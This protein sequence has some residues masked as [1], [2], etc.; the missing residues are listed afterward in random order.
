MNSFEFVFK[1]NISEYV[2]DFFMFLILLIPYKS[3]EII[4][5]NHKKVLFL[6][7]ILPNTFY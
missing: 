3:Q 5:L 4:I 6:Q 2:S 7:Y 1:R